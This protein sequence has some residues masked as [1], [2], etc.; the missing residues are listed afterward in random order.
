MFSTF[1]FITALLSLCSL[2]VTANDPLAFQWSLNYPSDYGL[3]EYSHER[4]QTYPVDELDISD[5]SRARLHSGIIFLLQNDALASLN[6]MDTT[7]K[8]FRW[9]DT[10]VDVS[11]SSISLIRG[12]SVWPRYW[13]ESKFLVKFRIGQSE[14]FL[15]LFY[16]CY[17]GGYDAKI[18]SDHL[19]IKD[20]RM[21][22]RYLSIRDDLHVYE[23]GEF[24]VRIQK[25]KE[26]VF[27][28]QF[29]GMK[30]W[31]CVHDYDFL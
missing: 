20:F 17:Y 10:P 2:L 21:E 7:L 12:K 24:T 18:S 14:Q 27:A 3:P 15:Y 19:A 26:G 6:L 16:D 23:S 11:P 5:A 29:S 28:M 31:L 30:C 1:L 25:G 13:Y 4:A 8:N 22:N 9:I